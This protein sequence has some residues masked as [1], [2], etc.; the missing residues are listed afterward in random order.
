MLENADTKSVAICHRSSPWF[1][2]R[3]GSVGSIPKSTRLGLELGY[4][5]LL[6]ITYLSI[7]SF[8]V[9]DLSLFSISRD[10]K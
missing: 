10:P 3:V 8:V 5:A 9:I 1:V 6:T 4:S 2:L 7:Y